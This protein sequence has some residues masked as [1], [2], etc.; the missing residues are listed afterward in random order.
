MQVRCRPHDVVVGR[1]RPGALGRSRRVLREVR[2]LGHGERLKRLVAC[3]G[4]FEDRGERGGVRDGSGAV[5]RVAPLRSLEHGGRVHDGS[6]GRGPSLS[7]EIGYRHGTSVTHVRTGNGRR[8]RHV[9]DRG[10]GKVWRV[11]RDGR[12]IV[13]GARGLSDCLLLAG[14]T[15]DFLGDGSV[16]AFTLRSRAVSTR[17]T[18]T[19]SDFPV[20][21]RERDVTLQS[22]RT[23][24][25]S[26]DKPW[27]FA[28]GGWAN[29]IALA[30]SSR[31]PQTVVAYR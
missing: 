27:K 12:N 5:T 11:C 31:N 20:D 4:L 23:G 25:D 15:V 2:G 28:D 22:T 19:A 3:I 17:R 13:R 30:G 9:E 24:V 6:R 29:P 10:I 8:V 21:Q 26:I 1:A 18:S 7:F 16:F 14:R